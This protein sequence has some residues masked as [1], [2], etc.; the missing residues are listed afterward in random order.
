ML[1]SWISRRETIKCFKKKKGGKSSQLKGKSS[2]STIAKSYSKNKSST[3]ELVKETHASLAV[4]PQTIKVMASVCDKMEKALNLCSMY[5]GKM[6][7]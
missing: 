3:C 2:Y 4:T 5:R 7:I 6:Y 1:K